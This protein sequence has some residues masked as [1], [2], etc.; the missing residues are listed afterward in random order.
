LV[1][2]GP[3]DL[4][5]E[6]LLPVP[7]VGDL[8]QH[9]LAFIELADSQELVEARI[10]LIALDSSRQPRAGFPRWAQQDQTMASVLLS[11][12]RALPSDMIG[13]PIKV[14]FPRAPEITMA[15]ASL[16]LRLGEVMA[17]LGLSGGARARE[18]P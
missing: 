13:T 12:S 17:T 4:M 6:A 14:I 2:T 10:A 7:A 9:Q 1:R 16:R 11:P 15:A 3:A 5:V 18:T 8:R